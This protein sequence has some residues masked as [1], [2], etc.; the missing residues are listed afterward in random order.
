M[1]GA[2]IGLE[3]GMHLLGVS[4]PEEMWRD[5]VESSEGDG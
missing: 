1:E 3:V 4:A 2:L 5:E